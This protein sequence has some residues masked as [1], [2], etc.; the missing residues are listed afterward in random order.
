MLFYIIVSMLFL[1]TYFV[2]SYFMAYRTF[3]DVKAV[4][5]TLNIIYFKDACIENALVYV[6]ENQIWNATVLK[7]EDNKTI[8]ST[9]SINTCYQYEKQYLQMR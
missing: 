2:A 1:S 9:A 8:A 3:A 4:V 7:S 5:D 6:R